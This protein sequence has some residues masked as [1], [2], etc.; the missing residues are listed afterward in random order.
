LIDNLH[1]LAVGDVAHDLEAIL[2]RYNAMLL[3]HGNERDS[4]LGG[5]LGYA[6]GSVFYE[7]I[8]Q[9]IIHF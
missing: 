7:T 9:K 6:L 3:G 2:H 5:L 4:V 1:P 8:G